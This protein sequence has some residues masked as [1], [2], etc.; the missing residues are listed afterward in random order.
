[1]RDRI[2]SL[3]RVSV[4]DLQPNPRNW[5]THPPEQAD[6]MRGLLNEIGWADALRREVIRRL[7]QL[8]P[9]KE[10]QIRRN[11]SRYGVTFRVTT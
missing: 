9:K 4:K 3:R 2:K 6:A 5:R 7:E 1:M 11:V 10:R 8:P